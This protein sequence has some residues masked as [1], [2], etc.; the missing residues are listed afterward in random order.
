MGKRRCN[1]R[2]GMDLFA[3]LKQTEPNNNHQAKK[4]FK[5]TTHKADISNESQATENTSRCTIQF[6]TTP[7]KIKV[8]KLAEELHC[9]PEFG[10]VTQKSCLLPLKTDKFN[11][12]STNSGSVSEKNTTN[13][14]NIIFVSPEKI[15]RKQSEG[16]TKASENVDIHS[17]SLNP[18]NNVFKITHS[19]PILRDKH[20][21][22]A[23]KQYL[24]LSNL[25]R[26]SLRKIMENPINFRKELLAKA[27][28][29]KKQIHV[30]TQILTHGNTSSVPIFFKQA[31]YCQ[32]AH[33]A[34]KQINERAFRYTTKEFFTFD[35]CDDLE[36]SHFQ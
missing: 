25:G 6:P 11:G 13:H 29:C 18:P 3:Y 34:S 22:T 27:R 16:M 33:R 17:G 9:S 1:S 35:N 36:N 8:N 15:A 30:P 2:R 23:S 21:F 19:T 31:G 12:C 5:I 26:V 14:N 24:K 28:D 10:T 32:I 7:K 20:S 4:I